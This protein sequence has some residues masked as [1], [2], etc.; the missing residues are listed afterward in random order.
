M[1]AILRWNRFCWIKLSRFFSKRLLSF[2]SNYF[3]SKQTRNNVRNCN[4]MTIN[5]FKVIYDENM[6]LFCFGMKGKKIPHV[7]TRCWL[8]EESRRRW[9]WRKRR[10]CSNLWD[11][12]LPYFRPRP[13]KQILS[14]KIRSQ[15]VNARSRTQNLETMLLEI[16]KERS[17]VGKVNQSRMKG[18]LAC[19]QSWDSPCTRRKV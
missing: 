18:Q 14:K 16:G 13:N 9:I 7:R 5:R 15:V 8:I 4:T 19:C 2:F 17:K 10:C 11:P 12:S 6:F 1:A 3:V